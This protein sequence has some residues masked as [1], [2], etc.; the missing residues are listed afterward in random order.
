M[1]TRILSAFLYF[2]PIFLFGQL[3]PEQWEDLSFRNVGPAGMSGRVTTIDYDQHTKS[4]YVGSAS[5]GLWRSKTEGQTWNPI[6]ENEATSSIGAVAVDPT[7]PDVIWV[8]TGEGNPRNSHNSGNGVYKSIDGG[9]TWMHL[10]LEA[11]KNI[12]RILINPSEPN[13][14]YIAAIGVA[15]GDTEERGVYKTIDGGASWEKVLYINERTGAA[16]LVMDPQNPNKL[17]VAMWEY[18]RWPWEFISGGEGSGIYVTYDGGSNWNKRTSEDGLPEGNLGRCGLAIAASDPNIVYALVEAKDKNVLYRSTDGART[19]SRINDEDAIGNRP[20][21]YADIYVDPSRPDRIFSLWSVLTRSDDGGKSWKTIAPYSSVHPDHHAFWIDPQNPNHVIDGNDGGLNISYDG[22]LSWRFVDNLPLAQ[23]YHIRV[24]DQTPYNIYGGMQ[25]NGSWKGPAYV[26]REGGI[27]N[28]LWEELAFG[29][30]FDVLPHPTLDNIAYAMWQEGNLTRVETNTGYAKLIRPVHPEG[31]ELRFNW[32][33]AIAQDPF[34]PNTIYF[35]SQFVHKSTEMGDAWEVISPDLTTNDPEHQKYSESGGLTYD[36]TGAENFT[37]ILAI[38]PSP[39]EAD[40]GT[41]WVGSDDGKLHITRDGGENWEDLSSKL[42]GMPEGAWIPQIVADPH[43]AGAA[44][45]VANDYRRN[46]WD[47]YLYYTSNYGKSFSRM[48]NSESVDGYVLSVV[49]SPHSP[50]LV[51]MGTVNGLYMSV[52]AGKSWNKWSD[53]LPTMPVADMAIQ[54]REH[55]LV[56]GTFGRSAWVLDDIR[57]LEYMADS[58]EVLNAR[59]ITAFEAPTAIQAIYRQPQGTR[60]AASSMYRGENRGRGARFAYWVNVD[61]ADDNFG[62]KIHWDITHPDGDTIRHLVRD[63]HDGLNRVSWDMMAKGVRWPSMSE[64]RKGSEDSDPGGIN[65]LPGTYTIHLRLG[66]YSAST[67]IVVEQD[68][69]L[70]FEI[71]ALVDNYQFQKKLL[72][73][74]EAVSELTSSMRRAVK[75]V[76]LVEAVAKHRMADLEEGDTTYKALLAGIKTVRDSL[77]QV[78]LAIFGKEN[79][80]GYYFE[81]DTW[82]SKA[83]ELGYYNYMNSGRVTGNTREL[84]VYFM[85]D[86]RELLEMGNTFFREDWAAFLRLV[87]EFDLNIADPIG[88]VEM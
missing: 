51:F 35:G 62:K 67:E 16:D 32:N 53:N 77:E 37:T 20:F 23:F 81:P 58:S 21:Y 4:L 43:K 38:E 34:E 33:A 73:Y 74:V 25:D 5:G 17:I 19:W 65:V 57:P 54:N 15:W 80:E 83:Q 42:K 59:P 30:G 8:G 86:T 63:Y 72:P 76:D 26:W 84:A 44:W 82:N 87:E 27:R 14:V 24:D 46:N 55:D 60:F 1:K 2:A 66:D 40:K 31:V 18:R 88:A 47:P 78:R 28:D 64:P 10:G 75:S 56:L 85:E 12:H 29:D 70:K 13:T 68:P 79:V 36:V 39:H 71:D 49:P 41:I 9:E 50:N 3:N 6:F 69:R 45:V 7:N 52:D 61:T 11:T 22:G 48:A